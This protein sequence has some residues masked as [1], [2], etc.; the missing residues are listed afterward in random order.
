MKKVIALFII[1]VLLTAVFSY[2]LK[3]FLNADFVRHTLKTMLIPCFT[4]G[5][6]LLAAYIKF[7]VQ[8]RM[9]YFTLAAWV[10]AI[11]SAVLVPAGIY[12]FFCSSPDIQVSVISVL[13]CVVVMS[14]LF[15]LFLSKENF[16]LTWWLGFN[17]LIIIN[18]FLFYLAV[19]Y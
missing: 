17:V 5:I 15:F 13:V 3:V 12:N 16:S 2:S 8:K 19:K 9:Q 6:L 11:G 4:W 1:A 18:M 10:C 14:G 7:P